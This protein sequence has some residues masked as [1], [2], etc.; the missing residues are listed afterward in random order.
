[1]NG[2]QLIMH[3]LTIWFRRRPTLTVDSKALEAL[4]IIAER[5]QRS[6]QEVAS[7]LFEQAVNEQDIQVWVIQRWEQLSPRQKQITAHICQGNSTR[8]IAAQLHIAQTTV[9]SHV[10]IILRKFDVNNRIAL[11][12]LLVHW[13]LSNYL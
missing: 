5:E 4:Q 10:E 7:R 11:R 12:Q 9:K 13:D 6:P 2:I 8:Q 3:D 1:M